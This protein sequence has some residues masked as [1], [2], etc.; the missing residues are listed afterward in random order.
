M[1]NLQV[2]L[3]RFRHNE[4]MV[5][6]GDQGWQKAADSGLLNLQIK[7]IGNA[8]VED[9]SGHQF[10]NMV[11]CS[12]LGLDVDKRILAGAKKAIDDSQTLIMG[13]SRLRI[14]ESILDQAEDALSDLFNTPVLTNVSCGI[15]SCGILPL[16]SSGH[17]TDTPP[18]TTIFDKHSHFT[19]N[20]AK[21]ICADEAE[22]LTAPHNDLN[23]VEDICKTKPNVLYV[24]D[25]I[26]SMGDKAP[27]KDLL[28]LQD[29][30]GLF[31]YIDD[32]HG[33]SIYG[34]NGEGFAKM[35]MPEIGPRTMIVA[36][37]W[38]GFGARGSVL[39][40]GAE[41]KKELMKRY[42]GGI[43][44][45]QYLTS[46]DCGAIL[47][48]VEIHKTSELE[49]LQKQ[50]QKNIQTV[51]SRLSNSQAGQAGSDF[52]IRVIR[53]GA[54]EKAVKR[55]QKIFQEGFYA[56]AVFFPVVE[57]GQAGLRIMIRSDIPEAD[58]IRLTDVIKEATLD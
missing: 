7:H 45:S 31:L 30:Y 39:M 55:S 12:Y 21:P 5:Q 29:K 52:P 58:L 17:I 26:Y 28:Y 57:K 40:F 3:H 34:K 25:G 50:L 22:V 8:R 15:H 6:Y 36:S 24:C 9:K 53:L 27:I 20:V 51:D 42:G 54:A 16:V 1:D 19:L 33:L 11:S 48:S 47:S 32:S 2:P 10:I 56:S 41:D 4:K 43:A 23:F 49:K 37:M 38:K 18:L 46:A 14:R 13:S 35:S 44:W